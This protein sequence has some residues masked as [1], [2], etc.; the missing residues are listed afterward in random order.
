MIE[1]RKKRQPLKKSISQ[2]DTEAV[3]NVMISHCL[4]ERKHGS[5]KNNIYLEGETLALVWPDI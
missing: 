4:V 2:A 5:A 1:I 3:K